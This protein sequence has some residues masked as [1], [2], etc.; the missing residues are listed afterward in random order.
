M[1]EITLAQM[2]TIINENIRLFDSV[3]TIHCFDFFET[4]LS[5]PC[6]TDLFR[7][8]FIRSIFTYIGSS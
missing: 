8:V 4:I 7:A 5:F 1:D 2:V 3:E 6:P